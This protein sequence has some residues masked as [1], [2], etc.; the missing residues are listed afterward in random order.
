MSE[1]TARVARVLW[2]IGWAVLFLVTAS[3]SYAF[4]VL[5]GR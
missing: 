2:P 1:R 5:G 4:L 3:L